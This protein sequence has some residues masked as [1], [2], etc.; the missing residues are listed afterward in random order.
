VSKGSRECLRG[1]L[2]LYGP[3]FRDELNRFG[4]SK[5]AANRQL[6]LMARLSAWLE[7][8]QLDV[9]ELATPR[10][11]QFFEARRAERYANL[12]TPRA[13]APL[14]GHLRRI[15]VMSDP[16]VPAP[17]GPAEVVVERFRVYLV[18]ER[19]LVDGTVRFYCH[20][21][22]LFAS[23]QVGRSG[24]ELAGLRADDVTGFTTRTCATR[25]LS[26]ARQVVSALRSFLRFLQLEGLTELALDGAVLSP[27]GWNPSLP[28][29]VSTADVTR[30]L[31]GCDR[32]TRIGRR[33]FAILKLLARLGLRGGEVVILELGDID[34]RSGEIVVHGKGRSHHRLPLPNDVG[35]AL[36]G[37]L[38]RGRP[39]SDCRRVFLRHH[40]P[41]RGFAETGA[42][43]GV[44]ERAC[45]RAG[46]AY[47][48]PHRLRHTVATEMLRAGAS[49]SDIGQILHHTAAVTTATYAK[50]DY[51]RLRVLARTWPEVAA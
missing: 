35:E 29:A 22:R 46:I 15:H 18:R 13:V 33:D 26:S 28:R 51:E 41:F 27:A 25:G 19:A 23:E 3:G 43:R 32:R 42:I 47:V 24:L 2:A 17:S 44:L 31:D 20:V 9:C 21:A 4:Y 11:E 14:V 49:L 30:L 40:A 50:V 36:A 48:S 12:L 10:V 5:S 8:E 7:D 37:Y 45:E 1:P 38:K 16:P 39:S 34:W 6:Q